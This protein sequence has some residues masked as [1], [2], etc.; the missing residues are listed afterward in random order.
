MWGPGASRSPS[1]PGVDYYSAVLF[2]AVAHL[3]NRQAAMRWLTRPET[4]AILEEAARLGA[5][6]DQE[7]WR[8]G[9]RPHLADVA[10]PVGEHVASV[11]GTGQLKGSCCSALAVRFLAM[12]VAA[13]ASRPF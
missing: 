7:A 5:T 11:N 4:P 13:L 12:I 9:S 2:L 6:A 1:T 10:G 3:Q 8:A